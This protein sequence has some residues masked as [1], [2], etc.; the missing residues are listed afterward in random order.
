M[1]DFKNAEIATERSTELSNC[2]IV[3][4]ES[5]AGDQTAIKAT[6]T[7]KGEHLIRFTCDSDSIWMK[8]AEKKDVEFYIYWVERCTLHK[9]KS[10]AKE[11]WFRHD[12]G[13]GQKKLTIEIF[14]GDSICF[15]PSPI[16]EVLK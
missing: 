5:P 10:T 8:S 14:A 15:Y 13:A 2:S 7:G 12:I 11:K 1:T 4:A 9:V 16:L 3:W 6:A